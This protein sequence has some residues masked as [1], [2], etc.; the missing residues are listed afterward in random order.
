MAATF[1]TDVTTALNAIQSGLKG[2]FNPLEQFGVK[3]NAASIEAK[4]MAMGLAETTKALTDN[5][6]AAAALALVYEQTNKIQGTF[7][8][9]ADG[10]AGSMQI[11]KAQFGD[12]AQQLG[13]HLIP[14][15]TEF[16]GILSKMVER[17][18]NLTPAQQK[19]IVYTGMI[20][21]AIGPILLVV[22]Q[23][24]TAFGAISGVISTVS[25][26]M[27]ASLIPALAAA[28]PAL[29]GIVAAAAPVILIIAAVGAA[30]YAMYLIWT[31]NLFGIQ[32]KTAA[33]LEYIK[34]AFN[35]FVSEWSQTWENIKQ[36]I[37]IAWGRIVQIARDI[38]EGIKAAFKIDWGAVGRAIIDGIVSGI[39]NGIGAIKSA[40]KDAA[41]A[42][43]D[44]AKGFL[45]IQSPS[46]VMMELGQ[47]MNLG[48]AAGI[49]GSMNVPVAAMA[50][51]AAQTAAA[52]QFGDVNIN[53][54]G[55]ANNRMDITELA[56]QVAEVLGGL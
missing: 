11:L 20:V 21:A 36:I 15:A 2:E 8:K 33:A 5:D 28:V 16:L 24:I 47:N 49:R 31:K 22:G 35:Q 27:S 53:V 19:F 52:S 10:V 46:K 25:T 37:Q 42:A 1:N 9:E 13:Q 40:A 30:I 17:F 14:I 55:N 32:E 43:L 39:R 4:A 26:F 44:A 23:A 50:G 6:K 3:I 29:G 48:M 12:I 56:Y 38:V 34:I 41:Q 51:T 7:Q 54:H 18:S 45:G